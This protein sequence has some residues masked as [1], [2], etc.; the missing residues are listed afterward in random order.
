MN[1]TF[2]RPEG[3]KG[4]PELGV[5]SRSLIR[6][7]GA[8]PEYVLKN[9]PQDVGNLVAAGTIAFGSFTFNATVF[10]AVASHLAGHLS[11]PALAG[12]V[13]LAAYVLA[14]DTYN[15]FR[16]EQIVSGVEQL[17]Q[18]GVEVSL[19]KKV[20]RRF[21]RS[22][23]LRIAQSCGCGLIVGV[24]TSLIV[25]SDDISARIK[26]ND[27]QDKAVV[28]QQ[29]GEQ[30]RS[31]LRQANNE[32]ASTTARIASLNRQIDGRLSGNGNAGGS[33]QLSRLRTEKVA[34]EAKL[35]SQKAEKSQA[36]IRLRAGPT[37]DSGRAGV[38]QQINALEQIAGADWKIM[39]LIILVELI[40]TG[41][42]LAPILAK[43]NWLP[44]K[45]ARLKAREFLDELESTAAE[46]APDKLEPTDVAQ[47]GEP[48]NDNI[49]LENPAP[50]NDNVTPD[51]PQKRGPGRPR[52][53][54]PPAVNGS[55]YSDPGGQ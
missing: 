13:A 32:I 29:L 18:A 42:D 1:D 26:A 11:L 4:P 35:A 25:Y 45:Y 17:S 46:M 48:A 23:F 9:C 7:A 39:F 2:F 24:M 15:Y 54:L 3:D 20:R 47:N 52:K 12:G 36:E 22:L 5:L 53:N 38:L 6:L 37:S 43:M 51:V 33:G 19:P 8:D 27:L 14:A 55:G 44:T 50:A 41:F 30:A 16:C 49:N 34:A 31:D 21:R 10:T 40:A 28:V